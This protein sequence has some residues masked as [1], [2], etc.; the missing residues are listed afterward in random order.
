[1]KLKYAAAALMLILL[2]LA[3]WLASGTTDLLDPAITRIWAPGE[4]G[5]TFICTASYI[6]PRINDA[7][8]WIVS[9]GHCTEG[10][11]AKRNADLS[12]AGYINWRAI[13]VSH[14]RV[15]ANP[16]VD[17]AL[18]T[19]PDV[20]DAHKLLWLDDKAP[21]DGKVYIH[22]FPRG[23]E[24][25]TASDV[26]PPRANELFS[27]LIPEAYDGYMVGYK[28]IT[29]KEAFPGTRLLL[30]PRGE[31]TGGSSGSPILSESGRVIGILW[32]GITDK[33]FLEGPYS[34]THDLV[35]FTPVERLHELMALLG[36]GKE[37]Q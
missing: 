19:V 18:G 34:A 1:M 15:I 9:A 21:E 12:I 6:L 10:R 16:D 23:V 13:L 8:G 25:V 22:G 17:L 35:L 28:R 3:P 36:V 20:R 26:V 27:F 2:V 5:D 32:G 4:N 14:N 33:N 29:V 24:R 7:L 31:V 37:P 30:V 11:L